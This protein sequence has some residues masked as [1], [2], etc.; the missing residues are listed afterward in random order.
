MWI[1]KK[2]VVTYYSIYPIIF[3]ESQKNGTK[4]PQPEYP[5]S[6]LRTEARISRTQTTTK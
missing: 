2:K 5:V 6:G 1:W 4:V 3:L